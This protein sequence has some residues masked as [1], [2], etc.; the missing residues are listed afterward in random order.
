MKQAKKAP[1]GRPPTIDAARPT[2]LAHAA[3]LFAEH[4]YEQ[5]SLQDVGDAVGISKAAV[6][7]YFPSKQDMYDAI[8]VSL[9]DGLVAHVR[10]A[11]EATPDGADPIRTFMR[12]HA[13]YFEQNFEGFATLLHGVGGLSAQMR[14]ARQVRV[15]DQYEALLRELLKAQAAAGQATIDD[16]GL[17]AK[18]ILSMLNWMSRWYKPGGPRSAVAIAEHYHDMLYRGIGPT[19]DQP[20]RRS[21][22]MDAGPGP[23]RRSRD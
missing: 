8:V 13:A 14:S 2:I 7:H 17:A 9:L 5:T 22:P 23:V 12:A 4:G 3:R 20:P 6:Y 15:R 16:A 10:A 21:S 11:V 1:L 19:A 18:G